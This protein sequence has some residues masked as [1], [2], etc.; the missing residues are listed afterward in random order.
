MKV[1][2]VGYG[3]WGPNLV[4]NFWKHSDFE[5]THVVDQQQSRLNSVKRDYPTISL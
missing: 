2:I 3:Y 4:R 1:A 5:V